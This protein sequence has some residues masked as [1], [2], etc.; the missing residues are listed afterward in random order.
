[1]QQIFK[2]PHLWLFF[3]FSWCANAVIFHVRARQDIKE[4]PELAE[5]YTALIRGWLFWGSLPW[6][7][8]AFG[9][10]TGRVPTIWH[11]FRPRDGNPYVLAL[12]GCV[13]ALWLLGFFWI[14]LRDGAEML[15]RHARILRGVLLS[16][17]QVKLMFLLC[18]GGGIAALI[19]LWVADAPLP[20][21]GG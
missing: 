19:F 21:R 2:S 20:F 1:M 8:M 16:P 10:E 18:V 14:F 6:L 13:V 17:A 11:Y 15:A 5:G 4:H 3:V 12:F 7:V 9:L